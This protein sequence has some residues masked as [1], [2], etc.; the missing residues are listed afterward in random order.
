MDKFT[1][2]FHGYPV[3]TGGDSGVGGTA[4]LEIYGTVDATYNAKSFALSNVGDTIG[5]STFFRTGVL[6]TL[7]SGFFT[8][9]GEVFLTDEP[10][11]VVYSND[12]AF[13]EFG[14]D[15]T[16]D[17]LR[18]GPLQAGGG[19]YPGFSED[20]SVGTLQ[21][22]RWYKLGLELEH[23]GSGDIGWEVSLEDFGAGGDASLGVV[24][25]ASRTIRDNLGLKFDP[26]LYAGFTARGGQDHVTAVDN[27]AVEVP[28]G[29]SNEL[30]IG[31]TF[32]VAYRPGDISSLVEGRTSLVVGGFAGSD[33]TPE[34]EPVFEF[35]LD[36]IPRG[37][38]IESATLRVN[39]GTSS[40]APRIVVTGYEGDGLA[41][42]SD[43]EADGTLVAYTG[44]ESCC[45]GVSVPLFTNFVQ[46][47]ASR[48]ASHLGLRLR[49][50]D[51]P[52]YVNVYA[53]ESTFSSG[54]L[55]EITYS[56]PGLPG[57]FTA[58]GRVD[59]A[60]YS[61][62]RATNGSA[63]DLRADANGSGAVDQ[64]DYDIWRQNYGASAP[65]D[66]VNGG[67][68]SNGLE[69]WQTVA[70]PNANISFGYP[71]VSSFDVTGDGVSS[72]AMRIR[73]GQDDYID[74]EVAG[75]GVSQLLFL[76]GGDY[77]VAADIASQNLSSGGNT[78][79]GRFELWLAGQLVDVV[80]MNG[81]SIAG[82]QVIRDSLAGTALGV[83]P[84]WYDL[85]LRF[86]RPAVNSVAIYGYFDNITLALASPS[87]TA[88]PE[89]AAAALALVLGAAL[90]RG[91]RSSNAG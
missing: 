40:G 32:D 35:P 37:A 33:N 89:P 54:P 24:M 8:T 16:A 44:P 88:V 64:G 85:E 55:L 31:P 60:D 48:D 78:A 87:I 63:V 38:R 61:V 26:A 15:S 69:G 39:T 53:G 27:F 29:S 30:V 90:M 91:R 47:L 71:L 82:G 49:S 2:D 34:E 75:G 12:A 86:L 42:L 4:S 50:D 21:D 58:D 67:F 9:Y 6:E 14:R 18:A 25:S 20:F 68:E 45:G 56:M 41:S 52:Q 7:G 59:A 36:S 70:T 65:E 51:L 28:G 1:V 77:V 57:D 84:G 17:F 81:Q 10:D 73:A 76:T 3:I 80:D 43:G 79:P 46:A 5:V 83:A 19:S 74:D 11:G 22:N 66:V 62:W 72:P 13:V 23:L